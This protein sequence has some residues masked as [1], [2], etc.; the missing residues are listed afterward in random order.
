MTWHEQAFSPTCVDSTHWHMMVR[1]VKFELHTQASAKPGLA[2]PVQ[3]RTPRTRT[4][5]SIS[6]RIHRHS[7]RGSRS[8]IQRTQGLPDCGAG[9]FL[10]EKATVVRLALA[11]GLQE[12]DL[13]ATVSLPDTRPDRAGPIRREQSRGTLC[14]QLNPEQ[15]K[16]QRC[17]FY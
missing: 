12:L 2:P 5:Q 4:P 11:E 17:R 16:A 14:R 13:V 15:R 10:D 3:C 8:G 6:C 9:F 1:F 7:I